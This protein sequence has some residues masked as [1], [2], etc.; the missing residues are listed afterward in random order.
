M[1]RHGGRTIIKTPD[2]GISYKARVLREPRLVV[3]VVA[4]HPRTLRE[5]QRGCRKY[6][7]GESGVKAVLLTKF[8]G[9]D[10]ADNTKAAAVA[11]RCRCDPN[12]TDSVMVNG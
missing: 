7:I 2:T 11:I 4:H 5:A 9:L 10:V 1:W 8:L 12:N 3:E 6:F